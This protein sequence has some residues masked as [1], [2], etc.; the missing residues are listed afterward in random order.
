MRIVQFYSGVESFNYFT[1]RI[2]RELKRLGHETF[3]L[4]LRNL[5]GRYNGTDVGGSLK[6]FTAF[7]ARAVDIAIS[8]DG[9]GIKEDMFTDLWD[10]MDTM[11]VNILV[12]HPLRFH[13]T[14]RKHPHHYVQFC[15][16]QNHVDYVKKYFSHEVSEVFFLPHAGTV[17]EEIEDATELNRIDR[18]EVAAAFGANKKDID[19][20]FYGTYYDP[21]RYY[22]DIDKWFEPGTVLNKFYKDLFLYMRDNPQ[23]STE[24]AVASFIYLS[25]LNPDQKNLLIMMRAAEPVDWMIR[26]YFRQQ[27]VSKLVNAGFNVSVLGRGWE[28]HPDAGKTNLVKLDDRVPFEETFSYMRRAK[29]NLN[30]MPFFK[31]GSHDRIFN[32]YLQGSVP[33]TDPSEF[34]LEKFEAFIKMSDVGTGELPI[35]YLDRL[36]ELP[37]TADLLLKNDDLRAKLYMRGFEK[38]RYRFI[39]KNIVDEVLE[40]ARMYR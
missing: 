26:H 29:V 18:R 15:C 31:A 39:W 38:T 30:V 21:N 23:E 33:L 17:P 3:I 20:L 12:D 9:L 14:M 36:D 5:D 10:S 16:D 22:D 2:D 13:D 24:Q 32:T 8:Y 6:D 4:D 34:L 27:A 40:K 7:A 11:A 25:G 35:F 28:N 1:N 19:I 37:A